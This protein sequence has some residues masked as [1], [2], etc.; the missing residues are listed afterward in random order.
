MLPEILKVVETVFVPVVDS[1][2]EFELEKVEL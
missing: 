1:V 2:L